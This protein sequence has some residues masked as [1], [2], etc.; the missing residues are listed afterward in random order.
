VPFQ[1]SVLGIL[2]IDVGVKKHGNTIGRLY[3]VHP[4][5]GELYYLR[6]LLMI[7][8]G[9]RNYVDVRTFNNIVYNTFCEACGLLESDN[10]WTLLFDEAIVHATLYQLRQLFVMVVLCCSVSNVCALF[11]KYW[12]YLTGDIQRSICLAFGN[13]HYVVPHEQLMALLIKKMTDIFANS[14]GNINDYDLPKIITPHSDVYDNRLISDEL[15]NEP[16][17]G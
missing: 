4:T 7:V 10:E 5:T 16:I 12:L 17:I 9:A 6:M 8:K 15:D 1:K 14:G 2:R 3:Y 13:P 11:D